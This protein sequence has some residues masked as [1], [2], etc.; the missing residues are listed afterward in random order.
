MLILAFFAKIFCDSV[1]N[2][3]RSPYQISLSI[4]CSFFLGAGIG[5]LIYIGVYLKQ[6]QSTIEMEQELLLENLKRFKSIVK[7]IFPH[8]SSQT[9][10][11][12]KETNF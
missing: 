12:I 10:N 7:D 9:S 6:C 8:M 1:V 4:F 11:G 5:E 3:I 2:N